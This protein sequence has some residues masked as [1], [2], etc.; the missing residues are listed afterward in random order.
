MFREKK[1]I[2]IWC[3]SLG[4]TGT[5]LFVFYYNYQIFTNAQ[6]LNRHKNYVYDLDRIICQIRRPLLSSDITGSNFTFTP[7]LD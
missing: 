6:Q 2:G 1:T 5:D 4:K 3:V 7:A